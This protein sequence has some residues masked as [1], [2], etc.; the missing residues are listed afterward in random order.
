MGLTRQ[1]PHL[2]RPEKAGPAWA[3]G[4]GWDTLC[5][6]TTMLSR[7]DSCICVPEAQSDESL[8]RHRPFVWGLTEF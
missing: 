8:V 3:S 1:P 5:F 4:R 7:G 2:G 6:W